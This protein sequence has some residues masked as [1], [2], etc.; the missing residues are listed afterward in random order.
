MVIRKERV[1]RYQN[2]DLKAFGLDIEVMSLIIFLLLYK[3]FNFYFVSTK[4]LKL[5][6]FIYNCIFYN[7]LLKIINKITN[8]ITTQNQNFCLL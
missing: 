4:I 7:F 2:F 1:M 3:E 5:Y 6:I 8:K